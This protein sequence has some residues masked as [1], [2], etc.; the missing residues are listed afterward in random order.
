VAWKFQ[1]RLVASILNNVAMLRGRK[2]AA[3]GCMANLCLVLLLIRRLAFPPK[4]QGWIRTDVGYIQGHEGYGHNMR[5]IC[6]GNVWE[7]HVADAISDYLYGQGRAIDVGAFI[8]YHTLRL[9]KHA[10]PFDVYAFEGRD[11][12]DLQHN[13]ARNNA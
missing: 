4:C 1:P 3:F 9:A 13:V 8:G 11:T 2:A 7:P 6:N 10:A 5:T 12:L